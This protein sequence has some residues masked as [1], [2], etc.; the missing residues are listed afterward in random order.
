MIRLIYKAKMAKPKTSSA[1]VFIAK[2]RKK[3]SRHAKSKTSKNRRSKNYKKGYRG[4][5]KRR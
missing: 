2:P 5:G 3:C 4:Q 1:S